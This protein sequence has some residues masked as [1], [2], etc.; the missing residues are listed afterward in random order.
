MEIKKQLKYFDAEIKFIPTITDDSNPC[1][2]NLQIFVIKLDQKQ[3]LVKS[4]LILILQK[5]L[6]NIIINKI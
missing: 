1:L 5:R 4:N 6:V 2:L 3:D